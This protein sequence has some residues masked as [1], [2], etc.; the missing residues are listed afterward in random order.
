MCD[1]KKHGRQ[2]AC[3][4]SLHLEKCQP[5]QGWGVWSRMAKTSS[6]LDLLLV[7][8]L[9]RYKK[10]CCRFWTCSWFSCLKQGSAGSW[11]RNGKLSSLL[12]V[13]LVLASRRYQQSQ[14]SKDIKSP[15]R[16]TLTHRHFW[17]WIWTCWPAASRPG[18][19]FLV[20]AIFLSKN[21]EYTGRMTIECA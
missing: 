18:E 8:V 12:N 13:L 11:P 9:Q 7:V 14:R 15:H 10:D 6:F 20:R 4:W 1:V 3:L 16:E 19:Q 2:R 17:T 5:S 21:K